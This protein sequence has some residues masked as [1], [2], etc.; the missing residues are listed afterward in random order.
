MLDGGEGLTKLPRG[1]R[2]R[3]HAPRQLFCQSSS[4]GLFRGRRVFD[5]QPPQPEDFFCT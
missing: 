5:L 4:A 2:G 3:V 1:S